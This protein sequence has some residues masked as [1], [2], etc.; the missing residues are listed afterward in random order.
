MKYIGNDIVSLRSQQ[1]M[2]SYGNPKYLTKVLNKSE[3]TDAKGINLPLLIAL[4]W[5]IKESAYK[6]LMK[7]GADVNFSP[8]KFIINWPEAMPVIIPGQPTEI[9]T[10]LSGYGFTFFC[11]SEISPEYIHTIASLN[12]GMLGK[13]MYNSASLAPGENSSEKAADYLIQNFLQHSAGKSDG[14]SLMKNERNIPILFQKGLPLDIDVSLSHD[15][16][17]VA[18]AYFI[19]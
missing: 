15:G 19:R 12:K 3:L 4:S 5:S 13:T 1:N 18:Y 11:I 8:K 2:Q 6:I 7:T 17:Y 9:E 10:S 14:L 16:N